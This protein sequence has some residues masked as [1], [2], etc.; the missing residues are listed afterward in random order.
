MYLIL[1]RMV[2]YCK[3]HACVEIGLLDLPRITNFVIFKVNK[4]VWMSSPTFV[5][6]GSAYDSFNK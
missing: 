5:Q 3:D 2:R 6:S 1:M 4:I